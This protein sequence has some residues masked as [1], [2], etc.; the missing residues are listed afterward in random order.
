LGGW[1]SYRSAKAA[2][3]Q[4]IKT[5]SIEL[6]RTHPQSI[7]VAIHPGTVRTS[8]TEKY[9]GSHPA[10]SPATAGQNILDVLSN[11]TPDQTGQ[12]FDWRGD[13]VEW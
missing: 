10:V 2:L 1:I 3:N 4:I 9:V 7:C 8:L 13:P 12:F 11:L 6:T 5:A